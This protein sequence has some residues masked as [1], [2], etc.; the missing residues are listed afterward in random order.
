MLSFLCEWPVFTS[1][2]LHTTDR[3]FRYA[4]P[5]LWNQLSASLHQC[6]SSPSVSFLHVHCS[7]SCHIFSPCQLSA[8]TI[9]I[10][11]PFTPDSRPTS[12]T[13]HSHHRLPSSL[14][15][16]STDFMTGPFLLSSS[17]F[18]FFITVFLFGS[19]QQIKLAT[20]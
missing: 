5:C 15:T 11:L 17:V 7:C 1:S 3:S 10:S 12:F 19:V 16:D 20:R 6:H 2:S 8:L 9:R 14:R 13:N 18:C 4:S